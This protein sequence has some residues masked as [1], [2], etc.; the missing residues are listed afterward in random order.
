MII[1]IITE[2]LLERLNTL[3]ISDYNKEII[4]NIIDKLDEPIEIADS[5][6]I[7]DKAFMDVEEIILFLNEYDI[8]EESKAVITGLFVLAD[9]ENT[10]AE[11]QE[12]I[13]IR[14]KERLLREKEEHEKTVLM[15][16]LKSENYYIGLIEELEL[17]NRVDNVFKRAHID[18][19]VDLFIALSP[20]EEGFPLRIRQFGK[21]A[22]KELL[23][24]LTNLGYNIDYSRKL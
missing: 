20:C 16:K 12:L 13:K 15:T 10:L 4:R 22:R 5:G 7:C 8:S 3:N 21:K 6:E 2:K 11:K 23:D 24:T 18:D 9:Y 17:S 19:G 1:S 14:Q